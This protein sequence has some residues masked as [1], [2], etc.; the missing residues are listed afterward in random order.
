M[1]RA[2]EFEPSINRACRMRWRFWWRVSMRVRPSRLIDAIKFGFAALCVL[3]I[4]G[5]SVR[6]Q[7]ANGA[8]LVPADYQRM[9]SVGQATIS[10]D[11]KFVAYTVVRYDRPGRPWGQLHV[12]DVASGKTTRIGGE[13]DGS[14]SPVWSPDSRGIAF[15]GA[16]EGKHE[17]AIVHPDGSAVTFLS[18]ASGTNAPL[19]GT[20]AEVT[21]S[22]DSKQIAFISATPE[23]ETAD[24][25]GDPI[26]IT[27]YMYKPD[28]GEGMTRF[29]DNRRL[30]IFIVDVGSKA[31]RQVTNGDTYEHSIDWS[32]RGDEIA[33]VSDRSPETDQFFNYDLFALKVSDG[34]VRRIT[35]TENAEYDPKFSP[36]GKMIAYRATKRG[37]TDRETTMEDTHVWVV[38]ADGSGR[39][40]FATV[41]NRQGAPV[42]SGDG[43]AIYFTVQERGSVHLYRQAIDG[44]AKA[45]KVIDG[46]VSVGSESVAKSGAM[47]YTLSTPG[48]TGE[49]YV[50]GS[51]AGGSAKQIT[52]L[53][54]EV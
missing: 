7:A 23:P 33:F 44:G 47:A 52:E 13:Q 50:R 5:G 8:G 25:T 21:W 40:E 35:A 32:P 53:N 3:A 14:G 37:L 46:A 29:N 15:S 38:N 45:E 54:K 18:E 27:R 12:L 4:S 6:G 49:L 9:R 41:D 11:G 36:D 30:H 10:P 26:M 28:A 51:G 22:P 20:G 48:D 43:R 34:S 2:R 24:A 17:L 19:P 31:V 39:R 16:G 42:W 1:R